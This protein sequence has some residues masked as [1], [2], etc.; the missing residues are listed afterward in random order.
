L[1]AVPII[2]ATMTDKQPA[3]IIRPF[4]IRSFPKKPPSRRCDGG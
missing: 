4:D 1:L 3:E 2:T